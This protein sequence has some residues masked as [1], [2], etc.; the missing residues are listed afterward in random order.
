MIE[1]AARHFAEYGYEGASLR[2]VQRE[3]GV[4]PASVHYHFGTKE[5]AYRAVIE[6]FLLDIQEERSRRLEAIPD[7]LIGDERLRALLH[8]YV[9]PHFEVVLKLKERS[10]GRLMARAIIEPPRPGPDIVEILAPIRRRYLTELSELFPRVPRRKLARA[11]SF[12]IILMATAA[13]DRAFSSMTGVDIQKE[14]AETLT[15]AV[16]SFAAGGFRQTCGPVS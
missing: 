2:A 14:S 3:A 8:A 13:F 6:S 4:N 7:S 15:E 1:T 16:V 10:Y 12:L 11:L 9:S 5:A